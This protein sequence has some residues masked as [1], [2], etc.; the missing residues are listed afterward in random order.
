MCKQ[1]MKNSKNAEKLENISVLFSFF[2][3]N[4]RELYNSTLVQQQIKGFKDFNF[5]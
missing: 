5:R 1:K 3:M 4:S 2:K